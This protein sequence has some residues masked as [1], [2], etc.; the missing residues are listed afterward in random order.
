M[1]AVYH[2]SCLALWATIAL[3]VPADIAIAQVDRSSG[4]FMLSHCRNSVGNGGPDA[5]TEGYCM[6]TVSGIARADISLCPAAEVTQSQLVRVVVRYL[7]QHPVLREPRV[8]RR[9]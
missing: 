2:R 8:L 3:L 5:F 4:N 1:S 9:F 6:G 7:D